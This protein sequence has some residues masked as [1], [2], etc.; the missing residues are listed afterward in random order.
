MKKI[1]VYPGEI[2]CIP[3]FMPKDDW[4]LKNEI[5]LMK[6]QIKEFAFGRVIDD[7]FFGFGR[8]IQKNRFC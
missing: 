6:I 4:D 7:E 8:D 1:I 2:F 5:Y 3:L